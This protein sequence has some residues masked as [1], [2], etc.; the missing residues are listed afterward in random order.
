MFKIGFFYNLSGDYSL[1]LVLYFN[2]EHFTFIPIESNK[3]P[4]H[5]QDLTKEYQS[6]NMPVILKLDDKATEIIDIY[7]I[8]DLPQYPE[9]I[10]KCPFALKIDD[11]YNTSQLLYR[12]KPIGEKFGLNERE[13]I[14]LNFVVNFAS[15]K[16]RMNE[17][18]KE[19]KSIYPG[20]M[21][22]DYQIEWIVDRVNAIDLKSI[23]SELY[24]E[25]VQYYG[26]SRME[27]DY[28]YN[29]FRTA[30]IEDKS[31]SLDVYL[32]KLLGIGEHISVYKNYGYECNKEKES[33]EFSNIFPEG[34]YKGRVL[35]KERRRIISNYS[36]EAHVAALCY[37][38]MAQIIRLEDLFNEWS[39]TVSNSMSSIR[40]DFV[41]DKLFSIYGYIFFEIQQNWPQELELLTKLNE[42]IYRV[43][44]LD[45]YRVAIIGTKEYDQNLYDSTQRISYKKIEE[46]I[47][48]LIDKYNVEILTTA[49]EFSGPRNEAYAYAKNNIF[50]YRSYH[51]YYGYNKDECISWILNNADH[52]Y[53]IGDID[54]NLESLINKSQSLNITTEVIKL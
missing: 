13:H 2:G 36:K 48:R 23:L 34:I 7:F 31:I 47:S 53:I 35:Q 25:V 20:F 46:L 42:Y 8:E 11:I 1:K 38:K 12:N 43:Q 54:S 41:N 29:I 45:D 30:R 33:L 50:E 24:V 51:K 44:T 40:R 22:S 10:K 16:K 9:R 39:N 49:H 4:R 32:K 5:Y 14:L 3:L 18:K 6:F 19:I 26:Y 15:A 27:E 17:L 37:E 21:G 28:V 52:I